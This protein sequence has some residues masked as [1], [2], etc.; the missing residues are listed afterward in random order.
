MDESSPAEG[1][2]RGGKRARTRKALITAAAGVIGEKGYDRTTLE[3]VAARARMSRGAIYGNFKDK[4]ELF[5]AVV[6]RLWQPIVPQIEEGASLRR[7][8]QL[9][10]KAVAAAA[11]ERLPHAGA[12]CA[13]QL[14]AVTHREMRERMTIE[15]AAIY[16]AFARELKKRVPPSELPMPAEQLVKVLDALQTGLLFTYFQTPTLFTDAVFVAAFEALA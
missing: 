2:E 16:K 13:F 10:G 5:L 3:E 6:E 9:L 11:K 1:Q 8:L 7:Q 14:Y 15:N 4:E 12:A